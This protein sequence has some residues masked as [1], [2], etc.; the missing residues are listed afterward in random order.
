MGPY[1][2]S[3][4][5]EQPKGATKEDF[6][7]S[8]LKSNE[9]SPSREQSRSRRQSRVSREIVSMN[10]DNGL[11]IV[12]TAEWQNNLTN[13]LGG[14]GNPSSSRSRLDSGDGPVS[15]KRRYNSDWTPS[16][17]EEPDWSGMYTFDNNSDDDDIREAADGIGQISLDENL[18]VRFHGR[19]SG[20]HLLGRS[21]RNDDRNEGGI[22]RL[23]MAR[24][25]PPSK[26]R[27]SPQDEDI[28]EELPPVHVQDHLI[29][30]YFTHIH[31]IFPAVHKGRFLAEYNAKKNRSWNGNDMDS[32]ASTASTTSSASKL[33]PSQKVSKLLLFSIFAVAARFDESNAPFPPSGE[34]WEAGYEYLTS[35]RN[36][37]TKIFHRSKAATVQAL[38]LLGHREYGMGSMEQAWA[39]FGMAIRM[40]VDLGF[41]RNTDKWKSN[42][43]S[44]FSPE[45]AQTRRQIWWCCCLGDRYSA[46]YMGRPL[47]IR[48]GDYD[49]PLPAIDPEEEAEPWVPLPTDPVPSDYKPIPARVLTSFCAISELAVIA[50]DIMGKIYPVVPTTRVSRRSLHGSLEARLHQWYIGLPEALRYDSK[51]KRT[52]PPPHVL[53]LHVR[54]WGTVLLLH[55]A[56]IPNWKGADIESKSA[57]SESDTLA[58]K[59]FDLAQGAATRLS[60]IVNTWKEKFT[61][62]RS[63]PFLT[64]YILGSGI[65]HVLTLTLRPRNPAASLGL[66]QCMSALKEMEVVWPSAARAWDLLDGVELR[67]ENAVEPAVL[68]ERHKRQ[69]D[70]AFGQEK[71]SQLLSEQAFGVMDHHGV[72]ETVANTGVQDLSQRMMAQMLGLDIPGIQPS[73]SFYPGYEWWP[74]TQPNQ[75]NPRQMVPLTPPYMTPS[76]HPPTPVGMYAGQSAYGQTPTQGG[77]VYN[78][79]SSV[80]YGNSL[81]RWNGAQGFEYPYPT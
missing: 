11:S 19:A 14:M 4:R 2:P 16:T 26:H 75:Q 71:S 36:I 55:R 74:R 15:Q 6:F 25:W 3:G 77:I 23:P 39:Y 22:W 53:F 49:T 78:D 21:E 63:T 41:H 5:I 28:D 34:M 27:G 43:Q 70:D 56:F 38:L 59:A 30:L 67:V 32:P 33:E 1:G 17:S 57:S 37:L 65:M 60:T 42:G 54:Y 24:V 44:I 68:Q 69:A 7:A 73:T 47:F 10:Q 61:L 72:G 35:A 29:S 46:I 76:P 66:R 9:K 12:P 62:K 80:D 64:S 31:P 20:L 18:E 48:E 50:G 79:F 52:I 51:S 13:L 8:I 45:E 81:H 40:A 58:L